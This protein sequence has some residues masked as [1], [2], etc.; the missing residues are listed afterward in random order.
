MPKLTNT[1]Q[2]KKINYPHL[3]RKKVKN[4]FLR[5]NQN[6]HTKLGKTLQK[7]QIKMEIMVKEVFQRRKRVKI[8]NLNQ[9][10]RK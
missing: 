8:K 5:Q 3:K 9:K 10:R 2:D 6:H 1:S 7:L 4:P